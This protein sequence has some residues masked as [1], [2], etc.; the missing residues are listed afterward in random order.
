MGAVA[1]PSP[2]M[3]L[4]SSAP[5]LLA[6]GESL[7]PVGL[8]IALGYVWRR[9]SPGGLD[10]QSARRAINLLVMYAFYPGLAYH[11]VSHARF[12]PDFYWVPV[13]TWAGVLS[14]AL[15]AWLIFGR[16]AR[17]PALG[18][19]QVGALILACAFGNILS[20]GLSVLQP[21]YGDDA[22]RYAIYADILGVSILFWSLGA[23]LASIWGTHGDGTF[24]PSAFFNT[25][26]RLPPVWAFT[27]ASR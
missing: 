18:K 20:M 26:V 5:S 17:F 22:S 7:A 11:V 13:Y 23:G 3:N 25:F 24:R 9:A 8:L 16:Q 19:P 27:P 4:P 12:G 2:N 6:G 10:A 14:A 21:L 15:L 1:T